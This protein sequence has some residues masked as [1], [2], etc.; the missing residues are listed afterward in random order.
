MGSGRCQVLKS[1]KALLGR[2]EFLF[3]GSKIVGAVTKLKKSFPHIGFN[4]PNVMDLGLMAVYRGAVPY[5]K[6]HMVHWSV[7]YCHFT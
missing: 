7:N 3:V 4:D 1:I 2:D 5:K 6:G